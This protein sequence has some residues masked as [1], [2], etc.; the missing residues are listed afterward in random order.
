[1]QLEGD[2][3]VVR[4]RM[5]GLLLVLLLTIVKV[6]FNHLVTFMSS[7]FYVFF[8]SVGPSVT[9]RSTNFSWRI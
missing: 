7:F 3:E 2:V 8:K 9:N 4:W 6:S 1:M 5:E